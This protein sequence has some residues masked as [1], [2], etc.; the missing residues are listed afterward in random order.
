MLGGHELGMDVL[1]RDLGLKVSLR[2]STDPS[3]AKRIGSRKGV[4]KVRHLDVR[5]LWLRERV[6]RGDTV[7]RKV[8]GVENLAD[9]LTKHVPRSCLD[10]HLAG[11]R[12]IRDPGRHPLNPSLRWGEGGGNFRSHTVR[13]P[14]RK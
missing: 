3:A 1:C 8:P 2:I 12:V 11:V 14:P 4:G 6:S 5:E 10:K 13:E 7:L 9:I